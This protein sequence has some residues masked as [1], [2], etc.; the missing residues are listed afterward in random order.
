MAV[1]S[2]RNITSQFKTT[3]VWWKSLLNMIRIV[4]TLLALYWHFSAF[5]AFM[6]QDRSFGYQTTTRNCKLHDSPIILEISPKRSI[7]RTQGENTIH[8][9]KE[10][11]G[12][13]GE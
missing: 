3:S 6:G 5:I 1:R 8:Y 12:F 9:S 4:G 7:A 11:G 13:N 2:S 10:G